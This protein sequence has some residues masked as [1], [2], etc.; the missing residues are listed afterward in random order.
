MPTVIWGEQLAGV[1]SWPHSPVSSPRV[2]GSA[3][4]VFCHPQRRGHTEAEGCPHPSPLGP[5]PPPRPP[6]SVSVLRVISDTLSHAPIFDFPGRGTGPR[7]SQCH[8]LTW[9][10]CLNS[11]GR[12]LSICL[13]TWLRSRPRSHFTDYEA[14]AQR[15]RLA[16]RS[17]QMWGDLTLASWHGLRSRLATSLRRGVG[18]TPLAGLSFRT[19]KQGAPGS[20]SSKAPVQTAWSHWPCKAF[21][22]QVELR[23]PQPQAF[24]SL[25]ERWTISRLKGI[26]I[27]VTTHHPR[28]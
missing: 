18:K 20:W 15:G 24:P 2:V 9:S 14:E 27:S 28:P 25:E 7:G 26:I 3:A 17:R 6:S 5:G 4:F 19:V 10:D 23:L 11:Q 13:Q 8:P 22:W 1:Y 12:M 21:T 16:G